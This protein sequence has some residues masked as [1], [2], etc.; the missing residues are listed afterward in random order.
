M[1][2]V[3]RLDRISRSLSQFIK[4]TKYFETHGVTL[5]SS[6]QNFNSGD[7]TGDFMRHILLSFAEFE[8]D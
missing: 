2:V 1:I 3:N 4:L 6:T 5:V 8:H 7:A